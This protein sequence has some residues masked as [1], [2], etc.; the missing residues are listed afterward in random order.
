MNILYNHR[1]QGRGVEGVHIREVVRGWRQRGH[2]VDMAGPPG[3]TIEDSPNAGGKSP[4]GSIYG[5][6]S[7]FMPEIG[8]ELLELAY[9]FKAG[10]I[11]DGY[12]SSK[13]YGLYYERYAFFN[14]AGV[15][16]AR[17]KGVPVI[18]E[19]NFISDNPLVR[20]RSLLLRPF[21]R[22]VERRIFSM[23]DGFV[24]V[25]SVLKHALIRMGIDGSC[26]EVMTNAA[27]PDV[28]NPA[29]SGVGIRRRFGLEDSLVIGFVGGFY[30]WHGVG[31]L[32]DA[33]KDICG[34]SKNASVLLVG[35]GP[36]RK[37]L[38]ARVLRDGLEKRVFFAGNVDNKDLP[39]YVA[40]FDM[41]V[42]PDSNDYG[43][44]M[45]IYE[46][47]SM[48]RPVV[49]PRLGPI[50][51]GITDG[52]HGILF[53]PRDRKGLANALTMLLE[54]E[55]LRESM[56]ASGRSHILKEHT[57]MKNADRVLALR[58]RLVSMRASVNGLKGGISE[59]ACPR[60]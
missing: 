12:F 55:D 27:D 25:S 15:G 16:R 52:V 10:A 48:A 41:A 21:Q 29:I 45:K 18:L 2:G 33:F 54:R 47:M 22:L 39:Q 57:W 31:F 56:G 42:M 50:E 53:A 9:N 4:R 49:A 20:K 28:F 24:A 38:E 36:E 8:F 59:T 58:E 44:P 32:L 34:S 51:D 19:I 13:D 17:K 40:A 35:D 30:P 7:R 14:F 37:E 1:T 60:D 26:I 11:I 46:Y 43:S 3:V 5:L 23:A 6:I